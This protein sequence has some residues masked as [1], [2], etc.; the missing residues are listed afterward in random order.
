MPFGGREL[1]DERLITAAGPQRNDG[2]R[3]YRLSRIGAHRG[4][5]RSGQRAHGQ[6]I[7]AIERA[8]FVAVG[9]VTAPE[10]IAAASYGHA[11]RL[12]LPL[13]EEGGVLDRSAESSTLA[14]EL[15]A[16]ITFESSIGKRRSQA[17][18]DQDHQHFRQCKP[19]VSS[20]AAP[21]PDVRGGQDR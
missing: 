3:G 20:T 10:P 12:I 19:G 9:W 15:R 17:D 5:D 13:G 11:E 2:V 7:V 21:V 16:R 8:P 4:G 18:D 6:H 14:L 1:D